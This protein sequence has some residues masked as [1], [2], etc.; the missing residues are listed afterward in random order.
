MGIFAL[1]L[2][3]AATGTADPASV[4]EAAARVLENRCVRCH[5]PGEKKGELDLTTREGL[6][7][8]GESGV[9]VVAGSQPGS[10]LYQMVVHEESPAMPLREKKLPDAEIAAIGAWVNAGLPYER[11]LVVP[12]KPVH[13]AFAALPRFVKG[14][15]VDGLL[16]KQLRTKGLG[17]SRPL[18]PRALVRRMSL[19]Q[20]G[21]F[22]KGFGVDF[23][24]NPDRAHW[25]KLVDQSMRSARF[26]ERWAQHW[27]DLARYADSDGFEGDRDRNNAWPYR[28]FVV[29]AYN[30]DLPFDEFVKLQLAGDEWQPENPEA[31]AAT[32]FLAAGE[33]IAP[34]V[35][36][37]N[38]NKARYRADEVD[39]WVQ[40]VGSGF[41]GLTVGCARCHDHKFDPISA[42][43]YAQ[44]AA[45]FSGTLRR[46]LP[47]EPAVRRFELFV[48]DRRRDFREKKME[49]LAIPP[50]D[51]M[52]LREP[53][54]FN[55]PTSNSVY[56]RWGKQLEIGN[57]SLF[58]V[59]E[60]EMRERWLLLKSESERVKT[61]LPRALTVMD[62]S[63]SPPP[64]YEY[65]RGDVRLRGDVV[66]PGFVAALGRVD[67]ESYRHSVAIAARPSHATSFR[68]AAL[69]LWLT[70]VDKGAGRLLARVAVNRIWQHHFGEP[71]VD[72]P[73]DFGM[74]SVLPV[75]L[76]LLDFLARELVDT[77]WHQKHIHRLILESLAYQQGDKSDAYAHE[78]D[79][80][81]NLWWRRSSRR[82]DGESLRDTILEVSGS[83]NETV[84]GPPVKPAID[85]AAMATRSSDQYP[86][87]V[88]DRS[89]VWRRSLY[90]FSKR[91]V[92][93]PFLDAFDKPIATQSCGRRSET[94]VPLQGLLLM[95][96]LFVRARAEA[97]AD[98]LV[99]EVGSSLDAQIMRAFGLAYG[100][101]PTRRESTEAQRFLKKQRALRAV[102]DG[103]LSYGSLGGLIAHEALADFC[104]VLF[105]TNEFTHVD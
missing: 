96:D 32:G 59:L 58:A 34:V 81:N 50:Y 68:R 24:R 60:P 99:R 71:L 98:R 9:A 104:Q 82:L 80:E 103:I 87:D 101:L 23:I 105:T 57:E 37:S 49:A 79:P 21:L 92:R 42:R 22:P 72:T 85:R 76:E 3:V 77:G 31:R 17:F 93:N 36:D 25:V 78:I 70:D 2:L 46:E 4:A 65:R 43:E 6:L 8:G 56:G 12:E 95:N 27:L 38:E 64:S 91:S 1:C 75:Q 44:L 67:P 88:P 61:K 94:T 55:N 10:L 14:T 74:Q 41:L 90:V 48:A 84:G 11:A 15:N 73:N 7:R 102:N 45:T 20:H 54:M 66:L 86:V 26:G 19:D 39:D 89:P 33:S 35:T 83:L 28:D 69:A 18:S 29:N 13:W 53:Q 51:C 52:V 16:L 5:N 40:V 47:L 100:R 63:S 62:G 30:S 97:F